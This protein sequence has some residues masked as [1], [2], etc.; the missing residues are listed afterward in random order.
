MMNGVV[1][2][3]Y[4]KNVENG[5]VSRKKRKLNKMNIS[6]FLGDNSYRILIASALFGILNIPIQAVQLF[7][8]GKL[9][10]PTVIFFQLPWYVTIGGGVSLGVLCLWS[11]GFV[12]EYFKVP[13]HQNTI[14]NKNNVQMIKRY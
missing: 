6:K 4:V 11:A 7:L 12:M 10:F 1:I 9:N 14:S 13:E 5:Y 2:Q 3:E 8:L